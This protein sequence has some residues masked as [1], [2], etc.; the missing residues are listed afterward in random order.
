[1]SY[2]LCLISLP[3]SFVAAEEPSW[4]NQANNILASTEGIV[5]SLTADIALYKQW[6]QTLQDISVDLTTLDNQRNNTIACLKSTYEKLSKSLNSC[7]NNTLKMEEEHRLEIRSL[8]NQIAALKIKTNNEIEQL[9]QKISSLEADLEE[10]RQAYTTLSSINEEKAQE[11]IS[12]LLVI[13]K[14]YSLMVEERTAFLQ[15]LENLTEQLKAH[16]YTNRIED[17]ELATTYCR[18]S[19]EDSTTD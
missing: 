7:Q 17:Q 14:Q 1:M 12:T 19:D 6:S 10:A 2:A 11:L 8:E 5:E 18:H 3:C 16:I 4:V 9:N 13:R 15:D